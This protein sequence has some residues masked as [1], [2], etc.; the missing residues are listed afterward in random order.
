M[1]ISC[2]RRSDIPAFYSD[3]VFNRIR[4]GYVQVRNPVNP[5]QVRRISLAPAD[6][7]CLVFWTKDPAPML[8]RLHLLT[9]YTYYLQFTLTPY[10]PDIESNLPAKTEIVDTFLRL[11]DKIGHQRTIWRYD[12]ILLSKNMTID[13]HLN[14]FEDLACRLSGY[15]D[16][17]V[18]S[19]MDMYRHIQNRMLD[20]SVRTPDKT[21]MRT[22]ATGIARIAHAHKM[23]VETCAEEID[24]N[25]LGI[26]HGRC[27]DDRLIATLTGRKFAA[28]K[29]KYQRELCG[30]A[31][32]VDIGEYNTCRHGCRYC[33]AN[34]NPK[35]IEMN[36]SRHDN[37]SPL[38]V[39]KIDD[40]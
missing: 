39:G 12:P 36:C 8:D 26:A 28:V 5:K 7:D 20:L 30:C 31:A 21:E 6:V 40:R 37:R 2:S 17:C 16:T 14:R 11:S 33:Y 24:L 32:S 29:D 13:N 3:W 23:K 19:F 15:T 27:I 38:L 10:G 1:I 22:L 18:I 34:I 4:E 9:D 35:K 25:D